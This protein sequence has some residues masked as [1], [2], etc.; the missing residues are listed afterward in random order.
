M[1]RTGGAWGSAAYHR[2]MSWTR[3]GLV[4]QGSAGRLT[5][6]SDPL[7]FFHVYRLPE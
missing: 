2:R 3:W 5:L 7:S 1:V 4:V 6:L